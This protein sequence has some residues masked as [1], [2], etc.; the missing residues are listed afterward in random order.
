[1]V[2]HTTL[3]GADPHDVDDRGVITVTTWA[4]LHEAVI[5]QG[6]LNTTMLLNKDRQEPSQILHLME[7]WKE[8]K[9]NIKAS[10]LL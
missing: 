7:S 9:M 5:A 1:M 4:R 6:V 10:G 3:C 2:N 8:F